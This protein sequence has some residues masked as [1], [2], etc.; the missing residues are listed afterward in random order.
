[1]VK[2]QSA[3]ICDLIF[4]HSFVYLDLFSLI[5]FDACLR[6]PQHTNVFNIKSQSDFGICWLSERKKN[7]PT[8]RNELKKTH[9]YSN[10]LGGRCGSKNMFLVL[11]NQS[12]VQSPCWLL[13]WGGFHH[14]ASVGQIW[15]HH[16]KECEPS[17]GFSPTSCVKTIHAP[18]SFSK[19]QYP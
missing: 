4:T 1:M 8:T 3:K 13:Q 19:R 7:I 10:P 5:V 11:I 16:M 18:C 12:C 17:C 15:F 2:A 9:L 6:C 14:T